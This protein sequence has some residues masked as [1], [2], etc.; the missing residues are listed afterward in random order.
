MSSFACALFGATKRSGRS[1]SRCT[2]LFSRRRIIAFGRR[3]SG[4]LDESVYRTGSS[5]K[6]R[7]WLPCRMSIRGSEWKRFDC[8]T[9]SDSP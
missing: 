9:S 1:A 6:E 7:C 8:S 5:T 3:Q 2:S 4:R